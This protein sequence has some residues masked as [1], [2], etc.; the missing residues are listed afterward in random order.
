MSVT[1]F[2]ALA[3]TKIKNLSNGKIVSS[4]LKHVRFTHTWSYF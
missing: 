4:V 2:T 3:H 1:M